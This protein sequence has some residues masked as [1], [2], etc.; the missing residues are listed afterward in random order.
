MIQTRSMRQGSRYKKWTWKL[1][2]C[3]WTISTKIVTRIRLGRIL[4]HPGV[5]EELQPNW[6][7]MLVI[8]LRKSTVT[9][10]WT[11]MRQVT[12]F[13]SWITQRLR[14][15]TTLRSCRAKTTRLARM[16]S[17]LELILSMSSTEEKRYQISVST[18]RRQKSKAIRECSR[19]RSSSRNQ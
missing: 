8:S 9:H 13:I 5:A 1:T 17:N 15:R 12:R 7:Q 19:L 18:S 2:K 10:S 14:R 4:R 3:T 6:P 16:A 11:G